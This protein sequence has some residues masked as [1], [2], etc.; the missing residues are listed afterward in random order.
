MIFD[1]QGISQ[2]TPQLH[3]PF[4]SSKR[5]IKS[6]RRQLRYLKHLISICC[7]TKAVPTRHEMSR[8][9]TGSY[10]KSIAA[11]PASRVT[12]DVSS[13]EVS[14]DVAALFWVGWTAIKRQ[15]TNP[16]Y[17]CKSQLLLYKRKPPKR[18]CCHLSSLPSLHLSHSLTSQACH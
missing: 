1:V 5:C 12:L 9:C 8:S 7:A 2:A 18:E 17:E 3:S 13:F 14:I 4:V 11:R 6:Q 15:I 16:I 10:R